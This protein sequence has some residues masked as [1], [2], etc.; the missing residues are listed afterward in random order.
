MLIF[1][2][3]FKQNPLK[4]LIKIDGKIQIT[5]FCGKAIKGE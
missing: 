2:H 5:F 1:K 4:R 3:A